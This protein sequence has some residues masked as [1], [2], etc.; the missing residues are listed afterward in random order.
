[1]Y[2]QG[3]YKLSSSLLVSELIF[4]SICFDRII[5]GTEGPGLGMF[6]NGE[7]RMGAAAA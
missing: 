1:M 4:V 5:T 7:F 2:W 3:N 6:E